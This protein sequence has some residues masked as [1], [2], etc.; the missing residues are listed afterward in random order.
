MTVSGSPIPWKAPAMN[1]LSS[2]TLA[3]TTSF[4][5]PMDC[6]SRVRSAVSRITRPISATASML[7][8]AFVLATLT[9]EQ[10]R[11]VSAS[12]CGIEEMSVRLPFV[13]PFWTSAL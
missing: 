11:S 1:G 9:E 8:P 3:K 4:A 6:R 7:M 12:A 2:G 5:Q 13:N 10:T